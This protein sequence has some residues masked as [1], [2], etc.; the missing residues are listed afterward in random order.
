[1][2]LKYGID[3]KLYF[4]SA[5][6]GGTPVWTEIKNVQNLNTAASHS[7]H[8]VTTRGNGG[9]RAQAAIL[10]EIGL[11]FDM[12]HDPA[13]TGYTTLRDA[14]AAKS[15][16]GIAVMNGD[17]TVAGTEGIWFDA[18]VMKW[19]RNEDYDKPMM[20]KVGLEPTYSANPPVLKTI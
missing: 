18:Q 11:E 19:E 4:C 12:I 13:D 15:V 5:G 6:I 1:M 8:D 17:I 16:I 7:K 10:K 2:G 3:G 9:F 14:F 20:M